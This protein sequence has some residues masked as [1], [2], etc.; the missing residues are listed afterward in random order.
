[1]RLGQGGGGHDFLP[2][3]GA[4]VQF[5]AHPAGHVHDAGA[6]AAGWP[7]GV[8]LAL[9][10]MLPCAINHHVTYCVV[11]LG[12]ERVEAETGVI[13][14]EGTEEAI[15]GQGFPIGA[16]GIRDSD[17]GCGDA[18]VGVRVSRA[19]AVLRL[20]EAEAVEDF[21]TGGAQVLQQVACMA[22][23][24]AAMAE[25][26]ADGDLAGDPGGVHMEAG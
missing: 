5:Q 2:L 24:P 1:M 14:T 21:L 25:H 22:G 13:H 19:E 17:T 6:T 23:K 11:R 15:F 3:E 4:A 9:F 8:R 20:C 7:L 26:V 10:L 12:H 18:E 16:S